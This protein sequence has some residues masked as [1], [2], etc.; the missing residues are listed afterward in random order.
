M[1]AP[2]KGLG[3][4]P[5]ME[6][7]PG[8]AAED[9]S[10]AADGWLAGLSSLIAELVERWELE[11]GD[12]LTGEA[13]GYVVG[14]VRAGTRPVVLKL[15]YPD[16]WFPER[17]VALLRWDG[18]GAVELIDHDPRGAMLLERAVPGT[19]LSDEPHGER[20]LPTVADLTRRLWVP[21]PEG[22]TSALEE[23]GRWAATF[24]DRNDALGRP[25]PA[26]LIDEA[27]DLL[28]ELTATPGE[29]VLLH[30]DLRLRNVLAAEREPWLA[31]SP[32]PLSGDR[33]F[34]LT[35][36]L[37]ERAHGV[38]TALERTSAIERWFDAIAEAV[39]CDRARFRAWTVVVAADDALRIAGAGG[40]RSTVDAVAIAEMTRALAR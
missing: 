19:P 30:G 20:A 24:R 5:V 7:G 13:I 31:V 29:P 28:R 4:V 33:E 15:T 21:A 8:D 16:G 38:L 27:I 17:V 37:L 3:T 12:P 11:L 18:D 14:A 22:I 23:A 25:M 6:D 35:A 34:D 26:A 9:I 2:P 32:Q 1:G 40:T 36:P 10:D 39:P